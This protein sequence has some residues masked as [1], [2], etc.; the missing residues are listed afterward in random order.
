M[1]ILVL[2]GNC[3]LGALCKLLREYTDYNVHNITNYDI[4]WNKKPLPEILSKVDVFVYQPLC[5]YG[6]YDTKYIIENV[7][8]KHCRKISVSYLYFLGYFPDYYKNSDENQK[9]ITPQKP[10]GLFPYG[11]QKI[12][13]EF[14][15]C[16]NIEKTII[17]SKSENFVC[18]EF[19]ESEFRRGMEKLQDNENSVDIK[20]YDF[21]D[22]NYRTQ[23]LFHTVNHPSNILLQYTY[24]LLAEKL[25]VDAINLS[26]KPEYLG[27]ITSIIYPCVTTHLGLQFKIETW[28]SD[29]VSYTYDEWLRKYIEMTLL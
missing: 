21:I 5:G 8:P 4:V 2:Y 18:K 15:K 27:T 13:T 1:T 6:N 22:K 3:Q 7:L 9:T 19:V 25:G 20:L 10:Y 23:K 16:A 11:H 14:S 28:Q 29:G 26:G 12:K 17:E 24:N